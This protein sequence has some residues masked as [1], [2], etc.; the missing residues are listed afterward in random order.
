MIRCYI[1]IGDG[2]KE[3]SCT[4]HGLIYKSSDNVFE[5][6]I[7]KRD[8]TSNARERGEHTDPRT[9]RDGFD[10]TV[11]FIIDGQNTDLANVN[12][13][14]AAF[15]RKLYTEEPGSDVRVYKEVT[16]YNVYKRVK[17]TGIPEPIAEA[18]EMRRS[19]KG[20]DFAEVEFVTRVCDPEKCDFNMKVDNM[21][22]EPEHKTRLD[23]RYKRI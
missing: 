21:S 15:N 6:P 18:K 4:A 22:R 10:Y 19:E 2:A 5:A 1:Q 13:V 8:V 14:I 17:V 7:K 12:A 9:V 23:S 16:L 3:D 20:Y 11:R